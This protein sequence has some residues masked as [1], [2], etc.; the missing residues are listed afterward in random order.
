MDKL[1]KRYREIDE[2]LD[3]VLK[4]ALYIAS[5]KEGE[6]TNDL[7]LLGKERAEE[8][9]YEFNSSGYVGRKLLDEKNMQRYNGKAFDANDLH[10]QRNLFANML[11]IS[12]IKGKDYLVDYIFHNLY[13]RPTIGKANTLLKLVPED[14][15]FEKL[16]YLLIMTHEMYNPYMLQNS[17]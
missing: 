6:F 13:K 12:I 7:Y 8:L 5:L 10:M 3:G 11:I 9:A 16:L 1:S 17:K 2:N 14:D 15:G 4:I